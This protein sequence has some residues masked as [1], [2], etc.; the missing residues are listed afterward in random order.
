M[1]EAAGYRI[2]LDA[3]EGPLDLLLYLIKKNEVDIYDIPIATI[4]G[5]FLE[6]LEGLKELDVNRAGD[7]LVMASTLMEV[8]SRTIL[9]VAP[10]EGEEEEEDPRSELVRQLL[11]YR[12]YREA[13]ESLKERAEREGLLFPRG[14]AEPLEGEPEEPR[15]EVDL[16]Q[17]VQA[18]ARIL[19]ETGVS[20]ERRIAYDEKP[21]ADYV[22]AIRER[23]ARTPRFTFRS[24]FE[25]APRRGD[26]IGLF[27]ALLE[28]IRGHEVRVVQE[29]PH[30]EI[31]IAAREERPEGLTDGPAASYNPAP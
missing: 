28:L 1:E 31:E 15:V 7:F 5:Q 29:K 24:L 16:W 2:R 19:E 18:F 11:E 22:A 12:K 27:L 30:E 9:P 13:A 17:L 6:H 25:G 14:L 3:F 4:T 20:R 10:G 21:V 8:K 23:L 26:L